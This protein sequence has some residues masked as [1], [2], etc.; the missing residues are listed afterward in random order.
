MKTTED[1]IDYFLE[2]VP[3]EITN[4]RWEH[5]L[6]VAEYA[7]KLAKTH[8]YPNPKLGYLAGIVHDIT[9]QK[10][11]EFH[12]ELFSTELDFHFQDIPE[13]AYHAFSAPLYL[14]KKFHFDD[15]EVLSAIRSHTLGRVQMS[16]LEKIIYASD[17]LGSEYAAKQETRET[18][19]SQTEENLNFGIYLKASKTLNNLIETKSRIY[20]ATI[21][22]FNESL[23]EI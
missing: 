12:L 6:R 11:K 17:F 22:T 1:W 21:D 7:E 16:S 18:W 5:S 2:I 20:Q 19:V 3:S 9:K 14:R 23:L 15:D 13:E 4:T 10:K 8:H